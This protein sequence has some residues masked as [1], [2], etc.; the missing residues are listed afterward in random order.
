MPYFCLAGQDFHFSYLLPEAAPFEINITE[1]GTA[2]EVAPFIPPLFLKNELLS[3]IISWVAGAQRQVETWSAPPGLL[4]RVAGGS[5]FYLSP[6]GRE[7]RCSSHEQGNGELSEIDRQILLGP[8]LV[9]ALALRG[10]W[11]LHASAAIYDDKLVLFLGESG[12]GKSTLAAYLADEAGW[13]L[14]ADDILP[15]TISSGGVTAWPHFPQLKLPVQAQPG[16]GLPEQLSVSMVC[17]LK[18]VGMNEMPGLELLT[19]NQ[20]VKEWLGHT[21][22]TRMFSPDL[23]RKHLVFC[24][25]AVEQGPIYRLTYPHC[26]E[27][28][29][30]VKELLESIC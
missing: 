25:Q 6:D 1:Q 12:Q 19:V 28:L 10:T 3:H 13:R 18:E 21:A 16:P 29:P 30:I 7:I 2:D 14:A 24:S 26:R 8:V 5:D 15:V 20:A 4:V 11:S 9:L 22:G 27:T 23:L 17:V